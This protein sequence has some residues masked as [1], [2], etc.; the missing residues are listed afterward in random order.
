M[1]RSQIDL[2][3]DELVLTGF[4]PGDRHRISDAF[5]RELQ[6]L[7]ETHSGGLSPR[8]DAGIDSLPAPA[9]DFPAG[10][11]PRIVGRTAARQLYQALSTQP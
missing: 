8:G 11:P 7:M 4:R 2:R 5:Q 1:N 9:F 3:I 10:M 6:R